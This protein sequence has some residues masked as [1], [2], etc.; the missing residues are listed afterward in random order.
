MN[1][2][3]IGLILP[4]RPKDGGEHQYAVLA[5]Q[6]LSERAGK[7]FD[8][9]V[10][11]GNAFWRKW[12]KNM[13]IPYL[14]CPYPEP[15]QWEEDFNYRHPSLAR[16]Y[17]S[18]MTPFGRKIREEKIDILFVIQQ[19]I[20]VPNYK[21]KIVV[22]VHDLMHKY[23]PDFPEVQ[24]TYEKREIC[25]KSMAKYASCILTDSKLGKRQFEESYMEGRTQKRVV[26]LPF[27]A[28]GHVWKAAEEYVAVPDKY[29]FY[30]AQFWKH[31]NHANL[32]RAIHI[33]KKE[34]E[35]IHLVLVGSE[36]N[37]LKEIRK[38]IAEH[39]LE[40]HITILG[41]VS[42][43]TIT[44]LYRHAIAMIMPSY[45]GPTNIPP[46][47]AMTLGCPVAASDK[48]AMPEQIGNAGLLF[49]PDSPEEIARCIKSLWTDEKLRERMRRLGCRRMKRWTKREF[50]EKLYKIIKAI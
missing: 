5:A 37:Y 10:L 47:E 19:N 4:S 40:S 30:P 14:G 21:V 15:E 28:P 50:G 23:E 16:L 17:Y 43:E 8:L 36:K 44:Y 38:L 32:V 13:E 24:M 2:K 27:V 6:C 29:V 31:K 12:C 35:D 3:K 20:F 42:N 11:S 18:Y 25:M 7:D 41:F 1:K 22:P 26:S 45:F 33:L 34:I 48:Y 39:G 46:L 49:N 9:I